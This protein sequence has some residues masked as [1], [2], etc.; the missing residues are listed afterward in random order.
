MFD[1]LGS[2]VK[3]YWSDFTSVFFICTFRIAKIMYLHCLT[4][5][6]HPGVT[7]IINLEMTPIPFIAFYWSWRHFF[8]E[9]ILKNS[10]FNVFNIWLS[11]GKTSSTCTCSWRP[12]IDNKNKKKEIRLIHALRNQTV[13]S[14]TGANSQISNYVK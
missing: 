9:K 2:I 14:P 10:V 7:I 4:S 12:K 6:Q 1:V 3:A 8:I 5:V 13:V 11:M